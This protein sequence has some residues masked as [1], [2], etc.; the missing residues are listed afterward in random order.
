MALIQDQDNE[1][2]WQDAFERNLVRYS[3]LWM[4][5]DRHFKEEVRVTLPLDVLRRVVDDLIWE[6]NDEI[7]VLSKLGVDDSG[8]DIAKALMEA[9]E[10]FDGVGVGE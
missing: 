4:F 9:A 6:T 5:I 1:T 8:S 2:L 7:R 3:D 10:L